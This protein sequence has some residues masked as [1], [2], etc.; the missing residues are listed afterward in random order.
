MTGTPGPTPPEAALEHA[1]RQTYRTWMQ[2]G[3]KVAEAL[4]AGA[5]APSA[6]PVREP[7]DA[8]RG[9]WTPR[10]D[11]ALSEMSIDSALDEGWLVAAASTRESLGPG[12]LHGLTVAVK[13]NIDVAGLPVRNGTP[14][15]AWREPTESAAAWERLAAA[16]ARC[17][18]KAAT[19]QMAWGV[20]TPQIGHP[21]DRLRVTGGSS[22]GCAACVAAQVCGGALGTDTG[23]SIRIPAALC[24]VVGFR[25]TT[26][27]VDMR[28]I[29]PLAP[30]LDVV[31]PL[32]RDVRTCAAMLEILLDKPLGVEMSA[33]DLRV[34]VLRNPGPLDPPTAQAY[35]RAV[36]D[37]ARSGVQ[38]I[39]L[40]TVLPR[41]SGSVSLLTMLLSSA[42]HHGAAVHADPAGFGGEAR[43]LLTLGEELE[44][45]APLIEAARHALAAST[46]SLFAD[47]QLDA[48]LTPT[49]PC[50]APPRGA[51]HVEIAGHQVPVSSALT[52]FTAWASV[53]GT[54]AVSIPVQASAAPV[55]VQVIAPP[56][57]ED[58]CVGLALGIEQQARAATA[59][60]QLCDG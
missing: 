31:G 39:A 8:V 15:G 24:G 2:H 23:G 40:D 49:T 46:A 50:I 59:R 58:V 21:L 9:S 55:G 16:G 25:P 5:P 7:A 53:T 14:R 44:G 22:G 18:G 36:V 10:P 11:P 33:P 43:A 4:V 17:V 12:A 28:G 51:D 26:G 45:H 38:I 35:T 1:T 54:P 13:D 30:E 20:T 41:H 19:H 52:R 37:L 56:N 32:A 29:T 27:S 3:I 48:F 47:S 6:W 34:G 42:G 57:C 60:D